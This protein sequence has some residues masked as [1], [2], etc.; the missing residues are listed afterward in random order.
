MK[1]KKND[2]ISF[3]ITPLIRGLRGRQLMTMNFLAFSSTF[4][5]LDLSAHKVLFSLKRKLKRKNRRKK[6]AKNKATSRQPCRNFF[7]SL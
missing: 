7:F 6:A 2:K 5:L 4:F 1:E 3:D